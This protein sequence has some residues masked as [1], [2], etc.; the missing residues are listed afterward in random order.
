M[1]KTGHT[2][3]TMKIVFPK[4]ISILSHTF[5]VRTD[6]NNAGGSFSFP[7]SEIVI[8]T[9]TLQSDPSYVFSVICHEVMEAVCVA[10]GTR[11]SDPSVPNDYKFFM[12]HKGF[13]V[14][15]SV[16]AKVIQQFIGK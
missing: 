11:Y 13:E 4:E 6:K 5:K 7:D 14:N 15:I 9:A 10:T 1:Q 12:D 3:S 8:G 16:F 2:C